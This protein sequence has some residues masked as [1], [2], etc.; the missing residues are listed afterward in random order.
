MII[1]GEL[2]PMAEHRIPEGFD[3]QI[4]HAKYGIPKSTHRQRN[5]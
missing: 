5:T 2:N 3:G 1:Y 4:Q